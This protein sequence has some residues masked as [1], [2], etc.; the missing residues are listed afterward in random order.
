MWRARRR[1]ARAAADRRHLRVPAARHRGRQAGR[2]DRRHRLRDPELRRERALL[3]GARLLRPRARPVVP[4]RAQHPARRPARRG[5]A[6]AS[7]GMFFTIEPMINL[8]GLAVKVLSDGWTAVTRDR[9]LSA[10]FEHTVGVTETGVR[11]LHRCRPPGSNIRPT[12]PMTEAPATRGARGDEPALS[13][14]PRAAAR[15]LARGRRPR[16]SP[17]TSCI[18]LV[19]FRAIPRRDVKPLAKAL[20]ARFG[21]FAEAIA[22]RPR[23]ARRGRGHRAR[24]RSPNSRSSRRAPGAS[25]RASPQAPVD[26]LVERGASTIAAPP[27]R[28]RTARSSAS[29]SS[30][31]R[32]A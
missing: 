10:Q 11:N 1:A 9:S 22:A 27:W 6:A 18:E 29:C 16:R 17:I 32:T 7:P 31:R 30:T 4:R 21:S 28:S 19:L 26:R 2:D 3:G 8:G 15:T 5:R 13:R 20:V 24:A 12:P 14:P 25:P 23:A